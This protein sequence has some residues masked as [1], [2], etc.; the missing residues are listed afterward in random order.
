MCIEGEAFLPCPTIFII[1][2]MCMGK[3]VRHKTMYVMYVANVCTRRSIGIEMCNY[4]CMYASECLECFMNLKG[5]MLNKTKPFKWLCEAW[6][7]YRGPPF[8]HQ[9]CINWRLRHLVI[10][11]PTNSTPLDFFCVSTLPLC[12]LQVSIRRC[13]R[14]SCRRLRST[15]R[16]LQG[17]GRDCRLGGYERNR[18]GAM[19]NAVPSMAW[20]GSTNMLASCS[21]QCR[22]VLWWGPLYSRERSSWKR[23]HYWRPKGWKLW[24]RYRCCI[25]VVWRHRSCGRRSYNT[26]RYQLLL[27][28]LV[29]LCC[30]VVALHTMAG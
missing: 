24:E 8:W 2:F 1:E 27:Y 9:Y 4:V 25:L 23:P 15:F 10:M 6:F 13:W 12:L 22:Q 3:H 14:S 18:G 7:S 28:S 5:C 19:M 29:C 11:L 17:T 26:C 30:I 21:W 16:C 20:R